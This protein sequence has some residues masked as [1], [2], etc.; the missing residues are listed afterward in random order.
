[1]VPRTGDMGCS[2]AANYPRDS[3]PRA[4]FAAGK[5]LRKDLGR[6]R[7]REK[8]GDSSARSLTTHP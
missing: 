5:I 6:G 4:M 2:V 8:A 1:M 7:E 3:I